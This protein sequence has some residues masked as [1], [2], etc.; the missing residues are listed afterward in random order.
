MFLCLSQADD[1]RLVAALCVG[2][3]DNG[4][5]QPAEKVDAMLTV[6]R[7]I[8]VPTHCWAVEDRVAAVEVKAVALYIAAALRFVPGRHI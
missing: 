3:V 8:I 4:T 7:T 2:H 1:V 6:G 5:V